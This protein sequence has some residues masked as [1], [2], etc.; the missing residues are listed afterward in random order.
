MINKFSIKPP[1]V[2]SAI[3]GIADKVFCQKMLN[4]GAG[5]VILGG[6]PA[7]KLNYEA[8]LK[9]ENRG[10]TEFL[11]PTNVKDF[12]EWSKN[13]LILSKLINNQMIAVNLR[14]V[15]ID[16]LSKMWLNTLENKID[17]L[18]LNL[19]CRQNEVLSIG[20]GENLLKN[21]SILSKLLF[22][23]S[24]I[25]QG[26]KIGVKI[27]GSSV[28]EIEPLIEV[29][30]THPISYIHIDLMVKGENRANLE[31]LGAVSEATRIP[32]IA[33]NSV[34]DIEDIKKMFK[35]GACAVSLARPLINKPEFI[36]TLIKQLEV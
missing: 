18:E 1:I 5:M 36:A 29:L 14:I 34:R 8:S 4:F 32:V 35:I 12:S 16:R 31:Q 30:E 17:V 23:I 10:R 6:F 28:R 20:G 11:P 7:D 24:E 27:R 21:M 13:N 19:H 2:Q 25:I 9:L 26:V 22:E 3:A 15:S 33:N